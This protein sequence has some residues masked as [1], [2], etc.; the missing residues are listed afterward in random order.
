MS[1]TIDY[2]K[3]AILYVDD[4]EKSLKSFA[5]AFADQFRILTAPTAQEGLRL[6]EQHKDE[7]GL[8][9]TD[10]RMPGEQGIWLLEKARELRPRI[11]RVLATAYSDL[12]AV[13]A[14]VNTGA[15][16]KYVNKPWDPPQLEI[17]LRQALEFFMLKHE[18]DALMKEK[19]AVLH[20]MMV[21]DRV[22]SLGL[23]AAG[24]SHHIRN[25]L[26]AVKTFMD[27]APSKLQ[28][29]NVNLDAL[30]NPDFW[31][32]YY[33]NVQGQVEKINDLLKDLWLASEKP[34][35]HFTDKV[36]LDELLPPILAAMKPA[37]DAKRIC[38]QNDIPDTLPPLMVDRPKFIRLFELLLKDELVSLPE[39]SKITLSAGALAES[40]VQRREVVVEVRNDGPGLSAEALRLL[41]DPFVARSD[42]PQE[43]GISLMACYFI[44]RHHGGKIEARSAEPHGT[45]FRLTLPV[46]PDQPPT[47]DGNQELLQQVLADD[48]LWEKWVTAE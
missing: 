7:I 11:V 20:H 27:L 18:R 6:L 8:L 14:A 12:D 42:S 44:T 32:D 24:L 5:R 40:P 35:F 26:V 34:P 17:T 41:F 4:E 21:A 28:E 48:T 19:M 31:K 3:F 39:G 10:Q 45:I 13:I 25:S 47:G 33:Q 23:L 2:K 1:E 29:E 15:I 22:V 9:M 38:L 43:Y 36:R 30:R 37:F 16:Y 46:N